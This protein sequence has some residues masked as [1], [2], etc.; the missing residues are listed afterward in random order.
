MAEFLLAGG[1][2]Q[3]W[4]VGNKLIT[5]TT[6]GS[7]TKSTNSGVCEKCLA[8]YQAIEQKDQRGGRRRH[9]SAVVMSRSSCT[10]EPGYRSS[11]DDSTLQSKTAF[12]DIDLDL[13]GQDVGVQTGSSLNDGNV[14]ENEP[15]ESLILGELFFS[16]LLI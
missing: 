14:L 6:S 5:I 1:Q 12:D 16:L 2:C 3:T 13:T 4:L 9:R 10:M 11:Q 15:L 7:G 8:A